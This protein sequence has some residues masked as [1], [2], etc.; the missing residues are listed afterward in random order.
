MFI[1]SHF[2]FNELSEGKKKKKQISREEKSAV[3]LNAA[4]T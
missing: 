2:G 4:I 3:R 1:I